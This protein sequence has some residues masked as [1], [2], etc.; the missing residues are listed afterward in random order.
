MVNDPENDKEMR[1]LAQADLEDALV[2]LKDIEEDVRHLYLILVYVLKSS[3]IFS[4][5]LMLRIINE[6]F[7]LNS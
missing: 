2:K 6:N 1:Q 4:L 7:A 5:L 3:L